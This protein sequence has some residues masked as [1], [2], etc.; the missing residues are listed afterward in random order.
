M[1][2]PYPTFGKVLMMS[3][4]GSK[5]LLK[6]GILVKDSSGGAINI[7]VFACF[8]SGKRSDRCNP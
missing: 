1:V 3:Q 5:C 7:T 2:N 8:G 6:I 4:E